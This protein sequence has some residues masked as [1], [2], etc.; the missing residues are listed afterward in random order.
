MGRQCKPTRRR[1]TCRYFLH[2]SLGAWGLPSKGKIT[3]SSW[4]P[5]HISAKGR[6]DKKS[7]SAVVADEKQTVTELANQDKIH[8]A[9]QKVIVSR[10][11][12]IL[13]V[14]FTATWLRSIESKPLTRG[15]EQAIVSKVVGTSY[16]QSYFTFK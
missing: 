5:V 16:L 13:L 4:T 1:Q 7:T 11:A 8:V 9:R 2:E 6:K 12:T 15:R 14:V 3:L 10:L